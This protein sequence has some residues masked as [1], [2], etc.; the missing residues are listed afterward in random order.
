MKRDGPYKK[1]LKVRDYF[2]LTD[3]REGTGGMN[4]DVGGRKGP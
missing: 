1:E 2:V 4:F 3:T